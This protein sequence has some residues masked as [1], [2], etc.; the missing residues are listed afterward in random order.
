MA[1][2]KCKMCGG[3]LDIADGVSVATCEYCGTK[4]TVSKFTFPKKRNYIKKIENLKNY[5]MEAES[6]SKRIKICAGILSVLIII[7]LISIPFFNRFVIPARKYDAA[8]TSMK[9]GRYQEAILKFDELNGYKDSADK[10]NLCKLMAI[11]DSRIGSTTLDGEWFVIAKEDTKV[12]LLSVE[13]YCFNDLGDRSESIIGGWENSTLRK[14]LNSDFYIESWLKE[15]IVTTNVQ[16]SSSNVDSL[17][18]NVFIFSEAEILIYKPLKEL[19]STNCILRDMH[20]DIY[21]IYEGNGD[22]KKNKH[23]P[24]GDIYI[25]ENNPL[26]IEEWRKQKII[27]DEIIYARIQPAIWIDISGIK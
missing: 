21:S 26:N 6:N 14:K 9:N 15:K 12:L 1:I 17:Q 27:N 16:S 5:H 13:T 24:I 19:L 2:F 20:N 3:S 25:K 18:D 4:Q 10:I 8:I 23:V 22:V 7:T 11:K